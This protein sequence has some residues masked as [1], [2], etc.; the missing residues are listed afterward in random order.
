MK[1][2]IASDHAGF[3]YKNEISSFLKDKRYEVVDFGCSSNESCDY[4][5]FGYEAALSVSNLECEMGILIC[6]SGV[7]MSI[8]ANKLPG[9]RAAL[10]FNEDIAKLSREHNNAN[11]ICI[12]ARFSKVEDVKKWVVLFLSTPFAEGRHRLRVEKISEFERMILK[13][14]L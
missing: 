12:A 11:I 3:R 5:D 1:I 9:V 13:R 8:I 2:A 4:P 14:K 7:G 6:G 10:C